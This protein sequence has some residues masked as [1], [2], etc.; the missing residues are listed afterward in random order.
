MMSPE[1]I[2]RVL[3][4]SGWEEN[5]IS[6]E[7]IVPCLNQYSLRY[8]F[9]LVDIKF[10]GGTS[11]LGNDIEYYENFGPDMLRFYTGIQVKKGNL[12]Q[13]ETTALVI[14][15]AQAFDKTIT[16]TSNGQSYRINR[17][18]V[19]TTGEISPQAKEYIIQQLK[20]YAK[21]IH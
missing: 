8:G 2:Q 4:S 3:I 12:G 6:Q 21:P 15:G 11:E 10:T 5:R 14:Q 7:I 18:I 1:M 16:D 17:W 19:V 20:R 13:S 9:K